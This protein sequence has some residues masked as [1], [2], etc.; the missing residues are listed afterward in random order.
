MF[1][2]V[3]SE[4]INAHAEA[5]HECVFDDTFG[6]KRL[7]SVAQVVTA[8]HLPVKSVNIMRKYVSFEI[9]K[10]GNYLMAK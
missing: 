5:A 6:E 7:L 3:N 9:H 4:H 10:D 1:F 8:P 2:S